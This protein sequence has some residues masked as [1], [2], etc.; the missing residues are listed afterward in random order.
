MAQELP[1]MPEE[2]KELSFTTAEEMPEAIKDLIYKEWLPRIMAGAL[3]AVRELPSEHRDHVLKEMGAACAGL[4]TPVVGI[5][6]GMGLEEY[7]KH[8]SALQPPLGPRTIEQVGD[9]V[10]VSYHSPIGKDGRP[11]CQCPLVQLKMVEPF[12][13][14]CSCAAN[15]GACWIETAIGK[16]C[17]K[18]EL[19]GSPLATGEPYCRYTV[20][21]EPPLSS[22]PRG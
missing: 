2:I 12:P 4:N 14:L 15:N 8:M 9:I 17:A 21:L 20:Y 6:P 7:K 11:I 16:P 18:A 1:Q 10:Q 13:E 5:T 3:K 19:M 22:T